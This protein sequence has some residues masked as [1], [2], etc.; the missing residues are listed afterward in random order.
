MEACGNT[1]RPRLWERW[2]LIDL[3]TDRVHLSV[4]SSC[5][6][7]KLSIY[8]F[9]VG[10]GISKSLDE[11]VWSQS[12]R[13]NQY[14]YVDRIGARSS[15]KCLY[16][17][18][19]LSPIVYKGTQGLSDLS[20][21]LSGRAWQQ[22][23]QTSRQNQSEEVKMATACPLRRISQQEELRIINSRALNVGTSSF[24]KQKLL[25]VKGHRYQYGH[26]GKTSI[27]PLIIR[28][29]KQKTKKCQL[30]YITK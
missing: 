2:D 13:D 3:H 4:F 24:T 23:H 7:R 17:P 29:T 11:N 15:P 14:R 6:V 27:P 20:K 28:S 19:L 1:Q 30:N 16:Y 9:L 25:D 5:L 22:A 26:R 10:V 18:Y 21:P 8:R 12:C